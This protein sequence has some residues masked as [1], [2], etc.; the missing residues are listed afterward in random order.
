MTRADIEF[1]VEGETCAAWFYPG[2]AEH[3]P[4]P[5]IVMAHGLGGT[6]TMGLEPY[7][8]RFAAAG[9]ACLVFDYRHFGGSTGEPRQLLSVRRQ[10]ADWDAA[11]THARTLPGV[12]PDRVVVW[13]TSFGGGHALTL[14]ARDPRITAAVAQCPFTDGIASSLAVDT[15]TSARVTVA[16]VRDWVRGRRGASPR[17]LPA[18]APAGT[19]AFMSSADALPGVEAISAGA[20]DHENRL[21]ARSAIDVFLYAPG[22]RA[23][24]IQCP[25]LVTLCEHDTVAPART[26]RRQLRRSPHVELTSYPVGHFDVYLGAPF[27]RAVEDYLEF[28]GRHVPVG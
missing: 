27:D 1:A 3:A 19:P 4:V 12:D 5:V 8:E 7:A 11:I 14:A 25:T 21:T 18:A 10:L 22:R 20:P 2:A 28:L 15:R 9:Y 16:A 6:R 26:A 23:R 24:R 13:G 17:Y